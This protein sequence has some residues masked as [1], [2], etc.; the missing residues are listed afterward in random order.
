[1]ARTTPAEAKGTVRRK[2]PSAVDATAAVPEYPLLAYVDSLLEQLQAHVPKAL[3]DW[4]EQAIHQARV[5]TRRLKAAL[6]LLKPV[7]SK[8]PRRA[9]GR[10]LRRVRRRLGPLRDTD[11]ML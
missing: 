11:V 1:M 2:S 5:S 6:D 8:R 10:V 4:D 7:L 3:K 9:F